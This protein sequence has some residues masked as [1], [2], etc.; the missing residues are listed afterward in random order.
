MYDRKGERRVAC[1]CVKM[2]STNIAYL[3]TDPIIYQVPLLRR[4]SSEPD[5]SL[6]VF[7]ARDESA[8]VYDAGFGK[9][10]V[11]DIPL[12]D[13][14]DYEVLPAF[15]RS[16][17][18]SFTRPLNYDVAS[19]LKQG[20]FD[21]LWVHGYMRWNHWLAIAAAK[22]L[23]MKVLI[24][25]EATEIS[26]LRGP[27]RKVMK[28]LFFRLF[29]RYVDRFLAIGSLNR[30]YYIRQGIPEQKICLVPYAVDNVF[31]QSRVRACSRER[32]E[33]REKLDLDSS[34]PIIL[35]AGKFTDRKRPTDLLSA[36]T[37]LSP[38]GRREPH[39]YL[40]Y[41]GEGE[42]RSELEKRAAQ[43]GWKSIR[44]VGFK[45]QTEIPAFYDLCDVFVMPSLSEPW[46]LVVN[47]AMNAKRPIVIS[48]K[49]GCAPDLVRHGE[50]GLIFRGGDPSSLHRALVQI[51]SDSD[52]RESMGLRSLTIINSWSYEEDV[53]GLRQALEI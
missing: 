17:T 5:I 40:L 18:T 37:N 2:R 49:V 52:R 20:Q 51:L 28:K 22:R 38:D 4:V 21:A 25:D 47:E 33:L 9:P 24:R 41:V 34:R 10:V 53:Y 42:L 19:K 16:R 32:Q 44:F 23:G 43:L 11:W 7:F 15:T 13:G 26:R 12:L 46:G 45:N 27:I 29:N 6:K 39:A 31:F 50:N 48:D 3:V 36:Y 14:Y 8:H 30:D 1:H 35:Y